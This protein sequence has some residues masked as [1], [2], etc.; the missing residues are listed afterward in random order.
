MYTHGAGARMALVT[1]GLQ[2]LLGA[3]LAIGSSPPPNVLFF[4]ADGPSE[5][6]GG[7]PEDLILKLTSCGCQCGVDIISLACGTHCSCCQSGCQP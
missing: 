7:G 6:V 2:G 4:L 5:S 3:A 1:A